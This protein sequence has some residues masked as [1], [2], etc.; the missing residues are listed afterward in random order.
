MVSS[1]H[2]EVA[3]ACRIFLFSIT[4]QLSV[5]A[6]RSFPQ[7]N[8][9]NDYS[10]LKGKILRSLLVTA[11]GL[12]AKVFGLVR[13]QNMNEFSQARSSSCSETS[14]RAKAAFLRAD[15]ASMRARA[16]IFTDEAS[17]NS[18]CDN[19]LVSG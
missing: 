8:F 11:F 13:D 19:D 18:I 12:I 5:G 14:A 3:K 17:P 1:C 2:V 16:G 10:S 7:L 6:L 4:T 9:L 15:M